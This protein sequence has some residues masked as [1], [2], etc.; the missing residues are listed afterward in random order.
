MIFEEFCQ[1]LLNNSRPRI[2]A[3][4]ISIYAGAHNFPASLLQEDL[5]I[6][7]KK[8]SKRDFMTKDEVSMHGVL[9]A[10][11]GFAGRS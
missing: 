7:S 6:A 11:K 8:Q 2:I 9:S 4:A 3:R 10:A 5:K 1:K